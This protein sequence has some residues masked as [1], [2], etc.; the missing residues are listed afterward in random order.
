MYMGESI[1]ELSHSLGEPGQDLQVVR[2]QVLNNA[3]N[4]IRLTSGYVRELEDAPMEV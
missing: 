1:P 3:L 2:P 4:G